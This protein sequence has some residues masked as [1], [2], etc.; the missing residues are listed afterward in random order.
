MPVHLLNPLTPDLRYTFMYDSGA[1]SAFLDTETS[2]Q[3]VSSL[4]VCE[5]LL[6]P[7]N[8]LWLYIA[9]AF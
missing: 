3:T 5:N 9:C 6:I 8:A 4:D 2:H 7:F 1:G